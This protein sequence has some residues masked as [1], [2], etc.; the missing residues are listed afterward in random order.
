MAA[1]G[2]ASLDA[3]GMLDADDLEGFVDQAL[4]SPLVAHLPIRAQAGAP[5]VRYS[6]A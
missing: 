1:H 5:P 6:W 4:R 3:A 2:L